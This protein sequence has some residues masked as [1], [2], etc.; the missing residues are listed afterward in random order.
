MDEIS[1]IKEA[2][3]RRQA[4]DRYSWL[5][6]YLLEGLKIFNTHYLGVIRKA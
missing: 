1:R 6:C 2:Y 3:A 4:G 5:A